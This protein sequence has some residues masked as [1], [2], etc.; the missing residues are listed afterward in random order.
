MLKEYKTEYKTE[1]IVCPKVNAHLT[2]IPNDIIRRNE[3]SSNTHTSIFHK[4][5]KP[6]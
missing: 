3:N 5:V 6:Y 1:Y 4:K 2:C